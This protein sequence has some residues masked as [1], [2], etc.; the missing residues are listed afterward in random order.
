MTIRAQI[1]RFVLEENGQD[2]VEY[3]MLTCFVGLASTFAWLYVSNAIANGFTF[4]DT[5]EQALWRPPN[6]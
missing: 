4:W 1:T 2:L 5:T 6:P 3:A